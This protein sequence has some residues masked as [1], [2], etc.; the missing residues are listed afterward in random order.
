MSIYVRILLPHRTKPV[1]DIHEK[2]FDKM[3]G[4]LYHSHIQISKSF[5]EIMNSTYEAPRRLIKTPDEIEKMRVAGRAGG[6]SFGYD[7]TAYCSRCDYPR[8]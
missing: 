2:A 3:G 5:L 8:T 7:Q 6:R 4:Y 1:K